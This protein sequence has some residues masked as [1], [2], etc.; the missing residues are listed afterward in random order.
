LPVSAEDLNRIVRS[1]RRSGG[2]HAIFTVGGGARAAPRT[3]RRAVG[4]NRP[5]AARGG[6]RAP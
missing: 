1:Q 6:G 5:R 3:R 2:V 4:R